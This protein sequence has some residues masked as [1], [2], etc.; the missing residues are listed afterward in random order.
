MS[1]RKADSSQSWLNQRAEAHRNNRDL[2][3]RGRDRRIA[4]DYAEAL[5]RG[6][7]AGAAIKAERDGNL[8]AARRGVFAK[9]GH[10]AESRKLRDEAL[11][12]K[13]FDELAKQ[14]RTAIELGDHV[15]AWAYGCAALDQGMSGMPGSSQWIELANEWCAS[16]PDVDRA[17]TK[18]S[19]VMNDTHQTKPDKWFENRVMKPA[20]L[21]AYPNWKA[22]LDEDSDDLTPRARKNADDLDTTFQGTATNAGYYPD[23]HD[24]ARERYSATFNGNGLP[25]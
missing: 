24:W 13:S 7:T 20:E 6:K 8:Q 2:N 17:V 16:D 23:S 14:L 21:D 11:A 22:L 4:R 3:E 18:L 25:S 15:A 5:K 9:H 12:I 10:T 19:D 1:N